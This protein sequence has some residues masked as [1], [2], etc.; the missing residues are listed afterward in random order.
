MRFDEQAPAAYHGLRCGFLPNLLREPASSRLH[1]F[2]NEA[3]KQ[4][5]YIKK[6]KIHKILPV[7]C[8]KFFHGVAQK[9]VFALFKFFNA[10]GLLFDEHYT[11]WPDHRQWSIHGKL[12]FERTN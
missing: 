12:K 9:Q 3:L 7:F 6:G 5:R 1:L 8:D 2:L 10:W 4:N 11:K